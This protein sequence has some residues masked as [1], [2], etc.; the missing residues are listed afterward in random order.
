MSE[1]C[2]ESNIII[3]HDQGFINFFTTRRG[4]FNQVVK[5]LLGD[6]IYNS[7]ETD[8]GL[9]LGLLELGIKAT[10]NS[11]GKA[12]TL[13]NIPSKCVRSP[14]CVFKT[15]NKRKPKF[16]TEPTNPEVKA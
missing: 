1:T 14:V 6:E 7:I 2:N 12:Y 3:D 16:S 5:R 4:V 8:E 11:R 9:T 10:I 13:N 15:T